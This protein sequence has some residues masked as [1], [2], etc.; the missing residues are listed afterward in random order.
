MLLGHFSSVE[1][2]YT[3]MRNW[4]KLDAAYH[5]PSNYDLHWELL[6]VPKARRLPQSTPVLCKGVHLWKCINE[7]FLSQSA[8]LANMH[9]ICMSRGQKSSAVSAEEALALGSL[10]QQ[11]AQLAT[12]AV[13]YFQTTP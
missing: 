11:D 7:G 4:Q 2:K 3:G 13:L 8:L 1:P 6:N 9:F 12:I 5:A 10:K